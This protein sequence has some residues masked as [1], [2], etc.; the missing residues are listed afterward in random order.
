MIKNKYKATGSEG[1][2]KTVRRTDDFQNLSQLQVKK[3]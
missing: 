1:K 2:E 3:T